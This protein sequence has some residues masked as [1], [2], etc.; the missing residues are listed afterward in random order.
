M[1]G[2]AYKV[3]FS[4]ERPSTEG[5]LLGGKQVWL[6]LCLIGVCGSLITVCL[7]RTERT[8]PALLNTAAQL[9]IIHFVVPSFFIY[10]SLWLPTLLTVRFWS[11]LVAFIYKS[12]VEMVTPSTWL[13]WILIGYHYVLRRSWYLC[14]CFD[15]FLLARLDSSGSGKSGYKPL[16]FPYVGLRPKSTFSVNCLDQWFP[17]RNTCISTGTSA[18]EYVES[19]IN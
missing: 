9:D 15:G 2:S 19:L 3:R 16:M 8:S 18:V 6:W 13:L 17:T 10:F 5:C 14:Q 4:T 12:T 1:F 11:E 7:A